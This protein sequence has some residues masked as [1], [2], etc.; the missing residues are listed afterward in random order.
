M[1]LE[2]AAHD[3]SIL[4]GRLTCTVKEALKATGLGRT[5]IWCAQKG[6][7]L[8]TTKVGRRRLILVASL[9]ELVGADEQAAA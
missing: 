4:S 7:K 8:K 2:S 3:T 6:G 9:R 5:T 1:S